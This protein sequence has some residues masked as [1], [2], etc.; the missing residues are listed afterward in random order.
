MRAV[1]GRGKT[2]LLE[3]AVEARLWVTFFIKTGVHDRNEEA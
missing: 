2:S 1:G 3:E